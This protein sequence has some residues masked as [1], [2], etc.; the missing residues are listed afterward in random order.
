MIMNS[1]FI[2]HIFPDG[3]LDIRIG[4]KKSQWWKEDRPTKNT[5][6]GREY[7]E[8]MECIGDCMW[9]W[10]DKR[11]QIDQSCI[12]WLLLLLA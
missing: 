7:S 2:N 12:G 11:Q 6:Q 5:A 10:V 1:H 3:Y 8:S 9:S 4:G